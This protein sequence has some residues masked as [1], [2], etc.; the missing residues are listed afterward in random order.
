MKTV[1]IYGDSNTHGTG[2]ATDAQESWRHDV[3]DRWVAVVAQGLGSDVRVIDEGLPGRTTCLDD[4]I[5]GEH[6]NGLRVL[7]AIL[8]SHAPIDLLVVMLGTN[9]IQAKYGFRTY[10]VCQALEQYITRAEQSGVVGDVL[11]VSPVNAMETGTY[12]ESYAGV[13]ARQAGM[14]DALSAMAQRRGVGFFD[15]ALVARASPI[16]GVHLDAKT[17]RDLGRAMIAPIKMRL[18]Q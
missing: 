5:K 17:S 3:A 16:D 1:L 6:Y 18:N 12:G 8:A 14:A 10:E 15:A 9:D 7:P 13:D 2:P 4:P 11:I